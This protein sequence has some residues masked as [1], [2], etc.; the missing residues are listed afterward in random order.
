MTTKCRELW[1]IESLA[2]CTDDE[3]LRIWDELQSG[4]VQFDDDWFRALA[5]ETWQTRSLVPTIDIHRGEV[6]LPIAE[7]DMRLI[8]Q[9]SLDP[10]V[11][12]DTAREDF[13][14]ILGYAQSFSGY[15]YAEKVGIDLGKFANEHSNEYFKTGALPKGFVPLRCC[16]FFEIRRQRHAGLREDNLRYIEDLYRAVCSAYAAEVP[17]ATV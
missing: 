11:R 4:H 8:D 3:V 12:P 7:E 6:Q 5:Y 1:P 14:Y 17:P 2:T 13:S 9:G 16:L 15:D 10:W